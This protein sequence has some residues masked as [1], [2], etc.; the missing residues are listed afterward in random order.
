MRNLAVIPARGGSKRIPGKNIRNFL[1]KPIIA[2]SIH[3][4]LESK[5]FDEVMVSTDDP[6]IVEI[7]LSFGAKVPFIR[8]SKNSDDHATLADVLI[9]VVTEYEKAERK[10]DSVCCILPTAPLISLNRIVE[11]HEK[12]IAEKRNSVCPVTAFS[13]PILRSLEIT[14][15]GK[16]KM[17]WPEHECIRSQDLKP[18]YHDSGSFVWVKTSALLNEKTLW[19]KKGGAIILPETEVQD[20]DSEEDWKL[21]EMKWKVLFKQNS[22]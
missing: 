10:F 7:A 13:H 21:A 11:A 20:I 2:Y 19:C 6:R 16:L 8:S 12:M 18:A 15:E 1:G 9:E 14:D 4:A 5:L 22:K 3:A 17:I